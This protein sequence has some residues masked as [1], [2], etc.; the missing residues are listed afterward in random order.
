MSSS[1]VEQSPMNQK[2]RISPGLFVSRNCSRLVGWVWGAYL[3]DGCVDHGE[4]ELV[5]VFVGL[6]LDVFAGLF[7]C[8][9]GLREREVAVSGGDDGELLDDVEVAFFGP[10]AQLPALGDGAGE[11][12]LGGPGMGWLSC[13]RGDGDGGS[14]RGWRIGWGSGWG[15][16]PEGGSGIGVAAGEE[17]ERGGQGGELE[18]LHGRVPFC[19]RV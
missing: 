5:V 9:L 18:G 11:D 2:P 10:S 15:L 7:A 12:L 6:G 17:D 14:G 16:G 13:G 19:R 4:E 1:C 8:F 3:A